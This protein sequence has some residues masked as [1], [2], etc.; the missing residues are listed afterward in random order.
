[1]IGTIVLA[2]G[3]CLF[4]LARRRNDLA[5]QLSWRTQNSPRGQRGPN[6][7]RSIPG[8]SPVVARRQVAN[9][10]RCAAATPGPP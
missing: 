2:L 8:L 9:A 7:D 3:G 10:S 1:M 5:A 4:M 6:R